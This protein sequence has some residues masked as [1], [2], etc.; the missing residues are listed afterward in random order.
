HPDFLARA[1]ILRALGFDVLISRFE[2]F[3][4]MAE[5]LAGYTDE[6]IG[7]AVGLPTVRQVLDEKYYTGLPGGALE[8]AG[9]LFQR[10]VTLYV[11]PTRDP[12]SGRIETL[13][14]D[15]LPPPWHHLRAFLLELGR[16]VPIRHYD[17]SYLSIRTPDVLARLQRGDPSWEELVPPSV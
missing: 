2:P 4:E 3:H 17:E 7:I 16:V 8:P 13:K 9:R 14:D 6:P 11:Y 1:D 15:R 5:Y 12:V 10:S